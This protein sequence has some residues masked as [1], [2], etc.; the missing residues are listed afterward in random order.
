MSFIL[1][2]ALAAA[3]LC[4][5]APVLATPSATAW[6]DLASV[7]W[8]VTDTDAADG[9]DASFSLGGAGAW[10]NACI[11][12]EGNG[13]CQ[14][15]DAN[16]GPW[17][18]SD[19]HDLGWNAPS[20]ASATF[21]LLS[22]SASATGT[23]LSAEISGFSPSGRRGVNANMFTTV[24]FRGAGHFDITVDYVLTASANGESWDTWAGSWAGILAHG[25]GSIQD[26]MTVG[27]PFDGTESGSGTL[28]LGFDFTDDSTR[29]L[30]FQAHTELVNNGLPLPAVPE[31]SAYAML[32]A[33][34]GMI[35][36]VVR[37]RRR[38]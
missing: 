33:G 28:H 5:A 1:R 29:W 23:A 21:P 2:A 14:P 37:R 27:R 6:V 32:L 30:Q 31:P 22:G 8:A 3:A 16:A 38:V 10:A 7:T 35:G 18:F 26:G 19:D 13:D 34:L 15:G 4:S 17:T 12:Q 36:L 24:G 25:N 9:I 20:S 11:G